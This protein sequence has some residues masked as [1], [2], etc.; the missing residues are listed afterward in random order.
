MFTA[1]SGSPFTYIY[2]SDANRDG[3][4][5]NDLIYVPKD[6]ADFR[7]VAAAGDTRTPS[8]VWQA[9]DSF[10]KSQPG[11][12]ALRGQI[13]PRN[14]GRTPWNSQVDL[15]V[16]QDLPVAGSAGHKAAQFVA[17]LRQFI[18]HGTRMADQAFAVDR[19]VHAAG[20]AQQVQHVRELNSV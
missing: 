8:Q 14:T 19:W 18:Q 12:D 20:G 1:S 4:G 2:A 3:T 16:M 5:N 17:G 15:R 10:I 11:L 13:A 7:Y 9:L 6:S